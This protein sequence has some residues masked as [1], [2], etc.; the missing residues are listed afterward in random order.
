MSPI[1]E[2]TGGPSRDFSP[3]ENEVAVTPDEFLALATSSRQLR[4]GRDIDRGIRYLTDDNG[5]KYV[6]L[7]SQLENYNPAS[8]HLQS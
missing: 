2:I 1:E 7:I 5:T 4:Q 8:L 3:R 6:A